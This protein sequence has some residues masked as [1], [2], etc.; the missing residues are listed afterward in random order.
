MYIVYTFL[1]YLQQGRLSS[2][3][4]VVIVIILLLKNLNID[5]YYLEFQFAN[6]FCFL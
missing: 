6:G 2:E 3:I 1:A 5:F 4:M